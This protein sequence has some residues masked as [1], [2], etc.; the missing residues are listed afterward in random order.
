MRWPQIVMLFFLGGNI[1]ISLAKDG[2]KR[3][4]EYNFVITLIAT[5]IEAAI[6]WAGGFWKT[7]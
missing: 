5:A 6:L 7:L 4:G 1:G 2:E 3:D